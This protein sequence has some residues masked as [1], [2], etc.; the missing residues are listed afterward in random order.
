MARSACTVT[1]TIAAFGEMS[2]DFGRRRGDAQGNVRQ[3][4]VNIPAIHNG[5]YTKSFKLSRNVS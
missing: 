3:L 5:L 2:F 1:G 4:I